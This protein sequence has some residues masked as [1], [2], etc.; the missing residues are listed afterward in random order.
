MRGSLYP[1]PSRACSSRRGPD[2]YRA[3]RRV[4]QGP[5]AI[6]RSL[7]FLAT[8]AG[9]AYHR[10]IRRGTASPC[11]YIGGSMALSDLFSNAQLFFR[12]LHVLA[13]VIWI[14]HLYFFNFVNVPFQG[15]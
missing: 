2:A 14:G 1:D 12:W 8:S 3:H 9:L 15:T 7:L 4:D 6:T 11:P 10:P 13:G 5:G